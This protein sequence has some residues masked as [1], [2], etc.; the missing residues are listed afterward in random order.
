MRGAIQ[1]LEREGRT[2]TADSKFLELSPSEL[3]FEFSQTEEGLWCQIRAVLANAGFTMGR[4]RH[5]DYHRRLWIVRV[6]SETNLRKQT[7]ELTSFICYWFKYTGVAVE[8]G[9]L[10]LSLEGKR[11]LVIFILSPRV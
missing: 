4:R 11:G 7:K 2:E 8:K 3:V 10:I 9:S 1:S 6:T 5:H